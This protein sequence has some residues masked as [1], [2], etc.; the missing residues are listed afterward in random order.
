MSERVFDAADAIVRGDNQFDRQWAEWT[1]DMPKKVDA[2]ELL[3]AKAVARQWWH[4]GLVRGITL[5][6]NPTTRGGEG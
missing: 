2:R 5:A 6:T 4:K 1:A 3:N